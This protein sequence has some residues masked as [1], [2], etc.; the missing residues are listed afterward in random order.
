MSYQI[1][2]IEPS[3]VI[4][5]DTI[6]WTRTLPDYPASSGWVLSYALLSTAG[7]IS[8]S[9][10]AQGSDHL[11]SVPA[12]TSA[13]WSAG[14]YSWQSYVTNGSERHVVASGT[15]TVRA[16][17]AAQATAT[18]TR[19][20]AQKVLDAIEAVLEGTA[21]S[22]QRRIKIGDK[23]IDKHAVSDL[24]RL[25]DYYNTEAIRDRA[26]DKINQGLRPGNKIL[27]RF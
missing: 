13:G 22:D 11:I 1:P 20:H 8:I 19:L 25:R 24:L 21:T 23:E 14:T 15:I 18:D 10:S 3:T 4:A 2:S 26:A 16:N 12:A 6:Q 5:G 9:G 7:K 17:F 27:T